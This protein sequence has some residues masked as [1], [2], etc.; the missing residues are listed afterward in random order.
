MLNMAENRTLADFFYRRWHP[1]VFLSMHQMGSNGPRFFLPPNYDPI[2]PNYDPIIWRTA[3]LLGHAMALQMEE[4][5]RSGVVQNAM[6]DYYW[7]GY[8][9]SAPLGHNTVCLLTEVAS[10]RVATPI[11]VE[12]SSL[13]GTPRGLP[14]YRA[15][16][17]FPNP[18]PGG[19]W[20]LRHIVDYDLS[21][22]RG[23]L[24]AAARYRADLLQNFY[25]M[26]QRAVDAGVR[27]GPFAFVIPSDQHDPHAARKLRQLLIGGAVE[28][29]RAI[30]PFRVA[31][32]F[33]PA[34]TDLVLMAQPFRAY[35]KTLLERQAYPVRRLAPEAPPERP[36]DVAGWTLPAQMG[37]RVDRYDQTFDPP[38]SVRLT[39][40][41]IPPA[42]IWGDDR[43]ISSYI[44]DGRG[45][46]ASVAINRLHAAGLEVSWTTA[47]V[48]VQGF[49][50]APGALLVAETRNRSRPVVERIAREL[51]L[52][53]TALRAPPTPAV[54]RLAPAR[55][56]LYKPWV[57]TIDE[58]W[59]RWLLEQYEFPFVT[60]SDQDIRRGDLLSRVDVVVLP[61]QA[62]DRLMNGHPEGVMPPEYTGG[63]SAAGALALKSFVDGG[64]TLVAL[65]SSSTVAITALGLPIRDALSAP[66]AARFF[67]PGSILRLTLDATHPLAFGMPADTAAFFAFG[68]AFDLVPASPATGETTAVP[69]T[70]RGV[71]RYGTHDTLLSGWLEGE[72][73]I[74][75]RYAVVEAHS[76][77][78]RAILFGFRP[79]HRGQS[80]AT[81]RLL[82]NALHTA[83]RP[84]PP[85]RGRTR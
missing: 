64:G 73:L 74:A 42:R 59:T 62:P 5:G 46:G 56:G 72:E 18:W 85:T 49:T 45:N 7:P 52:R 57:E 80:H 51:G 6:Y 83:A 40:T 22:A 47:T 44:V 32:T 77:K 35:A 11:T 67:A 70:A 34:G 63:L 21:A 36:Y 54:T 53:V 65:D 82:F 79:Q 84:L 33:Y 24:T 9:D 28:V 75:G 14:E 48:D 81:F 2:D 61:D 38:A 68:S 3:G 69:P 15:Q 66:E 17:N 37:V 16:I 20:T 12:A 23:L 60:L 58:G 8:E 43:R 4:D 41:S 29:H 31:D 27:G 39:D 25:R 55:V 30:E 50:Y 19:E 13:R 71:G 76:G 26:G 10:V 78:G 1:Q